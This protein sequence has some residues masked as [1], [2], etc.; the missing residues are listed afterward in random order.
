MDLSD[1]I[2]MDL[3]ELTDLD[4]FDLA[5]MEVF[6]DSND[7]ATGCVAGAGV[8]SSVSDAAADYASEIDLSSLF[9]NE[10]GSLP[11]LPDL[12]DSPDLSGVPNTFFV[13]ENTTGATFTSQEFST[14]NFGI[15]GI[16]RL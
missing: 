15:S 12:P 14:V 7:A 10:D 11:D 16:E 5:Y 2:N 1:L 13:S 4:V 3:T 8:V 9:S 6:G